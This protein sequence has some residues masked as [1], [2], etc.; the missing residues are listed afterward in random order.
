MSVRNTK[1]VMYGVE[2]Q[3]PHY[4]S[5]VGDDDERYDEL[6]VMYDKTNDKVGMLSDGMSGNYA[7]AGTVLLRFDE[8]EEAF[9]DG[10]TRLED[11]LNINISTDRK[12]EV[13]EQL[14]KILGYV[15]KCSLLFVNHWS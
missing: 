1:F 8:D 12:K 10:V 11:L 7:V 15:P 3:Y 13:E 5:I 6:N 2:I 4:K 9:P 14:E